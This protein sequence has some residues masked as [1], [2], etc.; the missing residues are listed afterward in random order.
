[1]TILFQRIGTEAIEGITRLGCELNPELDEVLIRERALAMFSYANYV[2]FGAFS[3]P[4]LVGIT[5]GWFTTRLYSGKQLELDHV[6]IAE[7]YR[8]HGI[9]SDFFDFVEKWAR[10]QH[11]CEAI[12]L[13][14]YVRN[15][16][17]HKFYF[18]RGY[19]ILGFHF[20]QRTDKTPDNPTLQRDQEQ[21]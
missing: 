15:P 8:A 20:Q 16:R 11:G 1:M 4:D 14:S 10:D 19:E 9:G 7:A 2:C 6:I 12:E 17:S 13:N 3:G 5:G 21:S 18:A